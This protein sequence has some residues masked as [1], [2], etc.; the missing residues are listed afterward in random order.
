M[1]SAQSRSRTSA[2]V[3]FFVC[4]KRWTAPFT[5]LSIFLDFLVIGL[6]SMTFLPT[7]SRLP[8]ISFKSFF[9]KPGYWAERSL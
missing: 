6:V 5:W 3:L 8:V 4:F 7:P 2:S 1:L 9:A